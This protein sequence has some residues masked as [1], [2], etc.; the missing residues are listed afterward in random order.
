[1]ERRDAQARARGT[2]L[3]VLV[4]IGSMIAAGLA[5]TM[6]TMLHRF[7]MD[8]ERTATERA[9]LVHQL[10]VANRAQ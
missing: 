5:F 3:I 1:V 4:A 6:N 9:Q 2:Y 7:A 8:Q 10:D